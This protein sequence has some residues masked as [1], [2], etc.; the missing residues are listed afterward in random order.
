MRV[1]AVVI[2]TQHS[3]GERR[4]RGTARDILKTRDSGRHP[5]APAGQQ[6]TKYHINPTG[7]FRH[8]RPA[9]RHRPH[10]T[11]DHR[12]H[13]RRHGPSRRRRFHRQGSD[14]GRPLRLPTWPAT[15]PRTSWPPASRDRCEVQLAYAI[16]VAEPVSVLVDTFGTGKVDHEAK[17]AI[18][19]AQIS[20]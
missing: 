17:L 14:Q 7:T 11:Q 15:S 3:P 12:G 13:L 9:W 6:D 1:D 18:W 5:G 20:S 4:Q 2:S 8:R 16:G 19:F 10:R